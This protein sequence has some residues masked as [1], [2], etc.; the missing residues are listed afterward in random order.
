[1]AES[2]YLITENSIITF[3]IAGSV[4]SAQLNVK[5]AVFVPTTTPGYMGTVEWDITC[6]KHCTIDGPKVVISVDDIKINAYITPYVTPETADGSI[7]SGKISDV[8]MSGEIPLCEKDAGSISISG[9]SYYVD[10]YDEKQS[11]SYTCTCKLNANQL[12][13]KGSVVETP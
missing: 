12:F 6:D 11:K 10:E 8:T 1:M 2:S 9:S 7:S 3:T 5:T 13:V 4:A